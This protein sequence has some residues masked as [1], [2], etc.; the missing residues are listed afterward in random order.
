MNIPNEA[1]VGILTVSALIVFFLGYNFL[2]GKKVFSR[3]QAFY[4]VYP[5]VKGMLPANP[6]RMRGVQVGIVESI[7]TLPNYD[8]L[9]TMS[10]NK[11]VQIPSNTVAAI[12]SD[13]LLGEMAMNLELPTDT[14]GRLLLANYHQSGDTL[15]SSAQGGMMDIA[16]EQIAPIRQKA[17]AVMVTLDSTLAATNALVRSAELKHTLANVELLSQKLQV[18]ADNAN[19][20]TKDVKTFTQND[21]QKLSAILANAQQMV[22]QLKTSTAKLD[23][24]LDNTKKATDNLA[25]VD[26]KKTVQGLDNTVA[27][28]QKTLTGINT[29]TTGIQ[30]GEGSMGKLMT[31]DQLYTDLNLAIQRFSDLSADLQQQPTR[32]LGNILYPKRTKRMYDREEQRKKQGQ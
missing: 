19:A 18:T 2:R 5:D 11:D 6:V 24:V 16:M 20:I 7:E 9:V 27:E 22:A 26:F 32:Y 21:M 13:G 23:P 17:E 12:V 15:R 28:L 30:K 25:T 4:A 10:V 31:D 29:L 14:T 3:Q 8:V 1:K